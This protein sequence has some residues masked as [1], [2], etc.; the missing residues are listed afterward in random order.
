M[1]QQGVDYVSTA[2]LQT[3]AAFPFLIFAVHFLGVSSIGGAINVLATA[4]IC[5]ASRMTLLK[6]PLFVWTDHYR[7][8]ACG[9]PP[10]L[11][12]AVTM[13]LTD[14][15][16]GT[17]FSAAGGGDPVMFQHIFWFF[18]HP[19]VILILPAFGV[20]SAIIPTF[21]RKPCLGTT[22]WFMQLLQ[23]HFCLL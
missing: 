18:G 3:G 14:K 1:R 20:V 23:S 16:F 2:C 17:L 19:G 22:L 10:V 11:A 21:C 13:L 7:L 12:G 6:L 15:F 4:S 8:F 5:V 9:F